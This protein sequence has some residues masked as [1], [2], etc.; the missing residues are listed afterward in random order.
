MTTSNS[1]PLPSSQIKRKG[2]KNSSDVFIG[3]FLFAQQEI[4]LFRATQDTAK[5]GVFCFLPNHFQAP[6]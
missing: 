2:I 5:K 4:N 6:Y 3:S 1:H